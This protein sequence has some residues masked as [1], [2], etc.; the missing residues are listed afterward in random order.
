M[1]ICRV[2]LATVLFLVVSVGCGL[3]GS[4]PGASVREY[5]K[6][7]RTYPFSDPNPIAA[8]GRIY[9][10]YRFDGFTDTPVDREWTVI[11]LENRYLKVTVLPEIGG[12]IWS[13]VEKSTGRSFIYD[14][15]VVKFRDVAMRGPW[16]SGG[17]EPNY[18][19][20]GHT[21]NCATPV[22]YTLAAR[23]DGSAAVVIGVLDL[24]TRTPWRLEIVLPADGAYFTTRSWWYNATPLEQ[25]YY[26]WMNAGIKAA[27]GLELIFPGTH[28]IG[29]A[30]E[31]SPWP[32]HPENGKNLAFYAQNDFGPSKSYHVVGRRADF[33]GGYWHDDDFGMAHYATRDDKL[34]KKAWI[35]GLSR[36]GMIWEQLLTDADG[37]YVEV[38]SGRLFNQAA[39]GSTE[40][41]FKHRGFDPQAVDAWTEYWFPVKGTKGFVHAGELGTLNILAGEAGPGAGKLQ[42]LF[43]PIRPVHD[44]IEV[45][46][47]DRVVVSARL[48]L[49]PMETWTRTIDASIAPERLRVR[50]GSGFDYRGPAPVL[51]RPL[52]SPPD[53]DWDSV[54]GRWLKGKEWARQR[55]YV[56]AQAAFESCLQKDQNYV[57]ALADLAA[58]RYRAL[59]Y[60]AARDL[61]RRALA[62]DTY[63]PASNQIYALA[64]LRLGLPADARDGF[65]VAASD[66]RFRAA[67]WTELSRLH[68][69]EGDLAKA[70]HYA[71]R[72]LSV[73]APDITEAGQL[74]LV[75]GRLEGEPSAAVGA[76]PVIPDDPLGH[77]ARFERYLRRRDAASRAAFVNGVRGEMPHET[78]LEVAIWYHSLGRVDEAIQVLSLAPPQAEVL[79]WLAFLQQ[80]RQTP[81]KDTLGKA[82]AASPR[83]VFP[84]RS[85]SA[86]VFEWAA[87]ESNGW[88]PKYYLALILWGR[89]ELTRARELLGE[90]GT[91]PDFAPFYAARSAAFEGAFPDRAMADLRHAAELDGREWRY[92]RLIA[93]RLLSSERFAEALAVAE[94]YYRQAPEN[95]ILG[96]LY[97]KCLLRGGQPAEAAE[98]LSALHV[99]PY[100]GASEGRSLH[101]ETQLMLAARAWRAGQAG[102]ALGHIAAAREWPENLGAGK[103]Y[104][105]DVNERLED[106]LEAKCRGRAAE[107]YRPD[108]SEEARILKAWE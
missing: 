34:G 29:H 49:A 6:V 15:H 96:M 101:R 97:A 71:R 36:R 8:P 59:D 78:F 80:A 10:Y 35:W 18:G 45:L 21:P 58:V 91:V 23:P 79:Y 4:V 69:R 47:G 73:E 25:P 51:S 102:E 107:P 67:A 86:E 2:V 108:T 100:E 22:D 88:R 89:N 24:L 37:Q 55:D 77:V 40:T 93:E 41:P 5:R 44:T 12:K 72:A 17:I 30:G 27:G 13:A 65:E 66:A 64:S 81:W 38:Q 19:I 90:C 105:T 76:S 9:P 103:P 26:T 82:E 85:E 20:I 57:P 56:H 83:L 95:Y 31:V 94:R 87:R 63:D 32:I 106:W 52:A 16:T 61:A 3:A 92:G 70:E 7:I 43:S 46:D 1:R 14:N 98:R 74:L 54:Q 68:L 62:V 53:F 50:I 60:A 28:A 11:E 84:F 39:E 42:L 33:F 104:P 48:S 75:I 99:L